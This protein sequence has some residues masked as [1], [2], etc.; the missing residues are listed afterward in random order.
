MPR[1]IKINT[2]TTAAITAS[3]NDGTC[4]N[5]RTC[6]GVHALAERPERYH[7]IIT[8]V[9]DADELAAFAPYIGPGELLGTVQRRIIDEVPR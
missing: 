7:V 5:G 6:E 1:T 3:D 2:L 9:T 4:E 8:E